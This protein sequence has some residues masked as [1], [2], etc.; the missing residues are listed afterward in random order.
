MEDG[1]GKFGFRLMQRGSSSVLPW[2]NFVAIF[3]GEQKAKK[4]FFKRGG[5]RMDR[6]LD[7]IRQKCLDIIRK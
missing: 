1:R 7:I 4:L 5:G 3:G 6:C 2:I